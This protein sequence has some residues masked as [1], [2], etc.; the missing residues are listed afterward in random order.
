MMTPV[1]AISMRTRPIVFADSEEIT[2]RIVRGKSIVLCDGIAI[3]EFPE[4]TEIRIKKAPFTADFPV[5]D[6][7]EFFAKVRN[8]LNA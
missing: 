6:G 4:N 2:V 7:S 3:A 1:S 8:K 5:R